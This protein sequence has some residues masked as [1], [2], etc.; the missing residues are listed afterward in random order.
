MKKIYSLTVL[1]CLALGAP[2]FGQ[3]SNATVSGTV[4]DSSGALIPGVTVTA[5]NTQTGIVTTVVTNESGAYNLASLQPGVYNVSGELPGFQTQSYRGVQL[6]LSQQ[7]RLNFTLQV[8]G[9]AQSV[10]VTIAADT[11]LAATSSSVG[12]VL[13]EYRVQDLPTIGRDALELVNVL[14]GVMSASSNIG[15][16]RASATFAGIYA[17]VGAVNT[18]R[19]G[20]PVSDGRYNVGVFASTSINPDLV[21][22]LRVV[23]APADAE[24]GRGVGQVQILTRSGTNQFKGSAVW[25]VQNSALDAN[26]WNGNRVGT[27]PTWYN[28]QQWTTSYGGPIV[29]NK[30]FF[31]G[32]LNLQRMHSRQNIVTPVLTAEARKGNFRF[33]PGVQNGNVDQ[34]PGGTGNTSIAPVVDVL[35]NPVRPAAATGDLQTVS[36]FNRDPLRGPDPTGFIQRMLAAMPLP[37]DYRS[38][39]CIQLQQAAA[40][41][42]AGAASATD[43]LNIANFRWVRRGDTLIGNQFGTEE[44]TNRNQINVKIDHQFSAR[45]KLSG[46][47]TWERQNNKSNPS[48][49]PGGFDGRADR[50][51]TVFTSSVVSTLSSSLVNEARWGL[52]RNVSGNT[53]PCDLPDLRDKL[54]AYLPSANGYP[55][56][57]QPTT[58]ANHLLQ[59]TCNSVG[60][61][62]PMWTYADSLSWTKSR[63]TFKGGAELRMASTDGYSSVNFRPVA[64]GGAGNFP[65]TNIETALIPG[66]I[67]NNLTRARNLLLTLS[68]SLSSVSQSFRAN[69]P[70]ATEFLDMKQLNAPPSRL[71]TTNEW[72]AFFKDDWKIRPSLTLNLGLRYEWYGVPWEGTG[73][74][75]SVAGGGFAAF[76]WSGRSW[77]DYWSYGPQKGALTE[78]IFVG[79]KSPHPD[80][81][82]YKDDRN[83]FGPAIGFS[84]S[85]PWFGKDKTMVRGGYGVSYLGTAGRGSAIDSAIGQGPGTIDQQTFTSTQYLDLSKVVLPLQ[86][87]KPGYTIPITERTQSLDAWDPNFVNPYIQSFNFS[88]TR[89][90]RKNVTADIKYVGTKGTKLYGSVPLNQRNYLT[91]GLKEALDITRAGG[92]APLLDQMLRGL[93]LNPGVAGFGAIGSVV[94]GVLQTGSMHL[95][96]NTTFRGNIANGNYTAVANSLNSSTA[97]TGQG[98]GLIRNGGFPENF[99]VNN[100]QF[101]N[102]T[103]ATNPG[104]SIYHSLQAQVTFRPAAGLNYQATYVWSKAITACG[105]DTCSAWINV[106]DRGLDR[107]LQNSDRR[108]DFRLNGSWELPFGP[109]RLLLGQSHGVLARLVERWQLSWIANMNTG[110]PLNV[111]STNTF[112]GRQRPQIA[113]DFPKEQGEARM[114][115]GLPNFFDAGTYKSLADPQCAK[116]T[117]LQGLQT[118]CT[119]GALADSQGRIVLQHAVPGT[120]GNLGDGWI[121]GPGSFRFDMSASKTIRIAESK[122]VQFRIDARNVLNHPILGNPNL[123][124]NSANFGQIAPDGVTG[125]RNF[126]GQLRFNF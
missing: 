46:S 72:S 18:M 36:I 12:G 61:H 79:P 32:L 107:G 73:M 48:P 87:N 3:S 20:I 66:L 126:Q 56:I 39:E 110:A 8:G 123:D 1:L 63:H 104:S 77:N 54:Y 50:E 41:S 106:L 58:F 111:T 99:I 76:G 97:V 7:V 119:L 47:Y 38:A 55:V 112:I 45:H 23:V 109:N 43:G 62:S 125:T 9:V 37:N 53:Q 85:L 84:W 102:V 89:E 22:E 98:G 27:T 16:A 101:N 13:P 17:G 14:P 120:L 34:I 44:D 31:F 60:T 114:T 28:R 19:D 6:G 57:A 70:T 82:I 71:T 122:S 25:N 74:T 2:A 52:R 103:F 49:W 95:R 91:N 24:M 30:T 64:A 75:A 42:G 90:V 11:L 67:G 88:I 80:Q 118:A 115:A 21:G 116:V 59:G 105:N 96:Q 93:N 4:S 69:S 121:T 35:G 65:V 83:N 78:V 81:Q 100:P 117:T 124:I 51:P 5:T 26:T 94:N 10:E 29:R 108:H 15:T 86:K 40:C 68:G 33:F 92:D 113:G